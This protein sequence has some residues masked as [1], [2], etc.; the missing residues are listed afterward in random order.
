MFLLDMKKELLF[1]SD[2]REGEAEWDIYDEFK[3]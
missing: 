1:S 3:A 2:L